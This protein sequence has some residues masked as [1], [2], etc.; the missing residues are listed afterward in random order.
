MHT[1]NHAV[2]LT[3]PRVRRQSQPAHFPSV[4]RYPGLRSGS[5]A[6]GCG[7]GPAAGAGG[8]P[9]LPGIE[10]VLIAQR[11]E[12]RGESSDGYLSRAV[13]LVCG[14]LPGGTP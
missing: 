2:E 12:Q 9:A 4:R 7:V 13:R 10:R 6:W 11:Q 8:A 14:L 1:R 3:V 5:A